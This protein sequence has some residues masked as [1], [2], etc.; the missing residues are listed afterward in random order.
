M[1]VAWAEAPATT[2]TIEVSV[3]DDG[4]GEGDRERGETNNTA[5]I[6][7]VCQGVYGWSA[8]E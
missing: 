8:G 3:D 4:A 5:E 2:V 7:A 6:E 1:S